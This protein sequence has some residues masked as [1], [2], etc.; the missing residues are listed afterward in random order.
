MDESA[1]LTILEADKIFNLDIFFMSKWSVLSDGQKQAYI[2]TA[3]HKIDKLASSWI[4]VKVNPQQEFEFPRVLDSFIGIPF[5]WTTKSKR[6]VFDSDDLNDYFNQA[7]RNIPTDIKKATIE[8]I[9]KVY[10]EIAHSEIIN[11][12]NLNAS[13][14][15]DG[16]LSISFQKDKIY[17][18]ES[19]DN[20][21]L[22]LIWKLTE[23]GYGQ[24]I[25]C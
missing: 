5:D 3:S 10:N 16:V 6:I 18:S 8:M 1:Y 9:K 12:Q 13:G 11:M 24:L 19:T 2:T 4:G 22:G 14:V 20:L 23:I 17:N 21:I 25:R 7:N 15:N